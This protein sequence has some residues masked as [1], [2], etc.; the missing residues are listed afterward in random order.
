MTRPYFVLRSRM[1]K[2]FSIALLAALM[3][4]S[5]ASIAQAGTTGQISGTVSEASSGAPLAGVIVTASS[6]TGTYKA[7]TNAQGFYVMTG[8]V[9]DTFIVTFTKAQYEV[10]TIPG[11]T[12]VSDQTV[13]VS[14]RMEKST[15]TIGQIS[16]RGAASAFQPT[17]L[18][19]TFTV[20]TKQID[21][22][23]GKKQHFSE[24][25]LILGFPGATQ[26][27]TG[28]LTLRGGLRSEI[29]FQFEGVDYTNSAT[30]QFINSLRINGVEQAQLTP[31]AGDAGQGN[32]GTGVF[33]LVLKRGTYPPTGLL[34]LEA[35]AYPYY[36]QFG[37]QYGFATPDGKVSNFISFLGTRENR[38]VGARGEDAARVGGFFGQNFVE[39][40]DLVDNFVY[41]FGKNRSNQFQV[42]YQ[43]QVVHFH[44]NLGGWTTLCYKTCDPFALATFSAT[45]GLSAAQVQKVIGLLPGQ[46]AV[47]QNTRQSGQIQPDD[48]IKLQFSRNIDSATYFQARFYKV[49]AVVPFDSPYR[50]AGTA[51]SLQDQ[52]SLRTGSSG[53]FTKQLDNKNLLQAGYKYE[54][55]HGDVDTISNTDGLRAISGSAQGYEVADFLPS[56][57]D[58]GF[59]GC[60]SRP[61]VNVKCGYLYRFFPN[62]PPRVPL[63]D[64]VVPVD[65]HF[66]ALF[67]QNTY[68]P[69]DKL[70]VLI[71]LR[72]D[73][74][75]MLLPYA[76]DAAKKHPRV[77]EPHFGF[78]YRVTP[79]DS[80]RFSYGRTVE[81]P[82][83]ARFSGGIANRAFFTAFVG[84]PSWDNRTQAAAVLC[85]ESAN[86]P[87]KDYAEQLYWEY[88]NG[89][90]GRVAT[91]VK[92]ETFNNYDLTY[93]HEFR[94]NVAV[95]ITPFYR[96]GYDV[97]T[98][99]NSIASINP[100]TG[101]PVF[102]PSIASNSGINRTF[103][104]EFFLTK[105]VA[106][107]LSGQLSA[108]Y[109][110]EFS[111]VPPLVAS[112]DTFPTIP[113]A[114]L[115][116]GNVY[117]VGFLSP[118]QAQAS[119][120]YKTRDGWRL[121][122]V[123]NYNKGYPLG[124][125]SLTAV[126]ING[127]PYNVPST[128][129]TGPN[130][131]AGSSL[132]IDPQNPGTL[133]NPNIAATRGT[134][135]R[136]SP[137]GFL[138]PARLFATASLE[139][140]PPK[141]NATYGVFVFNLFNLVRTQPTINTL[142]QPVAPGIAGPLT[143]ISNN[144]KNFP[145]I[146][147]S[148]IGPDQ[149]GQSPYLIRPNAAS[150]SGAGITYRFYYLQKF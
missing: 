48:T 3:L 136:S 116:L 13:P 69:S 99:G 65:A 115:A 45:N 75:N 76:T 135:E 145:G 120:S 144:A 92:P 138:S 147:F 87:C 93:A 97:L 58:P 21:T 44:F 146:G 132:Y 8:V 26:S 150:A 62:G 42:V 60:P 10:T 110:N 142:Y 149:F 59:V 140:T 134:P 98:L 71:G 123:I 36:H 124:V 103:G 32:S 86:L 18:V 130:G 109:L 47:V 91:P 80:V 16:V 139:Y 85:G 6:A 137:G 7:T 15:K 129:I 64:R 105:E 40:N 1:R 17:Q 107:G 117:H 106:Y 51:S 148:N 96:R 50:S 141:G 101:T 27:S 31:G 112:E 113:L 119:L 54:F 61:G 122:P 126:F 23:L 143:G 38:E 2:A 5:A 84:I 30:G 72:L 73:G 33:N 53:E 70:K 41:R 89:V 20:T 25:N 133:F 39:G 55:T 78:T 24:S 66:F 34:D 37:T 83:L 46:T 77:V 22:V 12:V 14:A 118:F 67:A 49:N 68:S 43:T 56:P 4:H 104:V 63:S 19:D 88:Q 114:S 35:S 57:T 108:T 102:T 95:K 79:V 125:G 127:V 111:N 74:A 9:P 94:N 100:L 121:N 81:I 29:G 11:V 128:N 28:N 90:T 131:P 52:G 82:P